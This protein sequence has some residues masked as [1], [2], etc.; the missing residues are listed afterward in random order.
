MFD[1]LNEILTQSH[2]AQE[3]YSNFYRGFDR[4]RSFLKTAEEMSLYEE[5]NVNQSIFL[6]IGPHLVFENVKKMKNTTKLSVTCCKSSP[7]KAHLFIIYYTW[8]DIAAQ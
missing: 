1:L 6:H 4:F 2:E 8:I 3:G 5:N 7:D